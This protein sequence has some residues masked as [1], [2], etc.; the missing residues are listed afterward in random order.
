MLKERLFLNRD[1]MQQ[2]LKSRFVSQAKAGVEGEFE[3]YIYDAIGA[4]WYGG[5]SAKNV[6]DAVGEMDGATQLNIYLNS[7]GGEIDDAMAIFNVLNRMKAKKT[8]YVDG[9]AASSASLIAMVGDTIITAPNSLWMIHEPWG[10]TVGNAQEMR[11]A[12]EILD[13]YEGTIVDT[14]VSRTKQTPKDI[15]KWMRD[16][17]WMNA[18]E[19]KARGFTDSISGDLEMDGS[20]SKGNPCNVDQQIDASGNDCAGMCVANWDSVGATSK[21]ANRVP[22]RAFPILAKFK[23]TPEE[24]RRDASSARAAIATMRHEVTKSLRERASALPPREK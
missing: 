9:L 18:E 11:K 6:V 21:F 5:V 22:D 3:L 15:K 23:N 13:K 17:T 12:A 7:P 14:Y 2:A 16:E 19:A 10:A 8:V 20:D 1:G 24:L 4:G